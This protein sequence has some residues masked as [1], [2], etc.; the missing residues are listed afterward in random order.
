MSEK[1][2]NQEN[3]SG[4]MTPDRMSEIDKIISEHKDANHIV[5]ALETSIL[6][7]AGQ[8]RS[9]GHLGSQEN[10]SSLADEL[11]LSYRELMSYAHEKMRKEKE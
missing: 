5:E 10:I 7:E 1:F 11:K 3:E 6:R 8:I 2:E 9:A 4:I